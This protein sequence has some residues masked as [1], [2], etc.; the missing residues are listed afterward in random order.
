MI[1]LTFYLSTP[2]GQE[3]VEFKANWVFDPRSI[4]R[5]AEAGD[6]TFQKLIIIT[7][8]NRSQESAIDDAT[9]AEL[10]LLRF[11]LGLFIFTKT[12]N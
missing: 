10:T 8:D 12:N 9:P 7:P 11:Q 5:C 4:V 2:I 6:M 3:R 1:L